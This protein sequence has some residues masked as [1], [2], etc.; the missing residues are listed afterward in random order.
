MCIRDRVLLAGK[1]AAGKDRAE[2]ALGQGEGEARADL[3]GV[4]R[5]L[6][7]IHI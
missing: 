1:A 4:V 3:D 6:S 2:R 5:G 7:L